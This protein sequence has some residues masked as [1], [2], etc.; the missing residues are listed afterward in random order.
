MSRPQPSHSTAS[1]RRR[2]RREG[3][4]TVRVGAYELG[5]KGG[6]RY[7]W[8]DPYHIAVSLSW[9]GFF[10]LFVLLELSLNLLFAVFY[11]LQPGSVA[12]AQ[13]GSIFDAFFFSLETLATV[14][15]GVMAPATLYGHVVSGVEI[16]VGMMFVAIM[17]G[18]TFVRFSRPRGKFLWADKAVM[19]TY[20]GRRTLMLRL[21]N[22]RSSLL[23]NANV[24]LSALLGE[25]SQEGQFF[26]RIHELTL[27]R[28]HLPLFALTW[29]LMHDVDDT[30][31]LHRFDAE[32]F[33]RA[34]IRLFV[35]V[36]AHDRTL[37]AE[38]GDMKDYGPDDVVFGMR[39][40]DAVSIDAQ[41]RTI[42]DLGRL[43]LLEEDASAG[44]EAVRWEPPVS[45]EGEPTHGGADQME[46]STE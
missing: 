27:Q 12:N 24:R 3:T 46:A 18:L 45:H 7:D 29:T 32:G 14:G 43:S 17:T 40:A 33:A 30:S 36:R 15:Y 34:D 11:L 8:R 1:Q 13:P 41:G 38:V 28:S 23:T 31:P 21:A 9:P 37:A 39:Y 22:G 19:S 44:P 42:A 4:M 2:D 35:T 10:A 25:R 20:N 16:I 5:K 26:R 6:T